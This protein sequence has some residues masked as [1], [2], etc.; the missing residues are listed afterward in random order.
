MR[1]CGGQPGRPI[2]ITAELHTRTAVRRSRAEGRPSAEEARG[3]TRTGFGGSVARA[4]QHDAKVMARQL[5]VRTIVSGM[6]LGSVLSLCN[7]YTGLKIGLTTNMSITAALLGFGFWQAMRAFGA[8]RFG[9]LENNLSQTAASA[10]A[11]VASAGLVAP[12]PALAI[13]TGFTPSWPVLSVWVLCVAGLGISVAVAL[14]RQMI[15]IEELPFPLGMAA[16]RTLEEM[17]S[18]GT[19]ALTRVG[20]LLAA[21]A[22]AASLKVTRELWLVG[23]RRVIDRVWVPGG[24]PASGAL[25]SSTETVT[26]ASLGFALDP[27][28]L[29]VGVGALIGLRAAASMVIG[30]VLAWGMLGPSVLAAGWVEPGAPGASWYATLVQWFLWPGVAVMVTASVA[31][32]AMRW[33][34]YGQAVGQAG[35]ALTAAGR[36]TGADVPRRWLRRVLAATLVAAV[37]GQV[38]IFSIPVW[39]ASLGVALTFLLAV[40]AARVSGET[41]VT[42]IGSMGKVTQLFF[43]V[44]APA[45]VTSNL[46]AANVT[47]GAASQCADLLHDFKTGQLLGAWPR[48]QALAQA[49]G[50]LA[51]ALAGSA[52]YLILVPDPQAMLLTDEWPAPAVV[53]WKA[54]AEL[55]RHGFSAMP[56]GGFLAMSMGAALGLGL[57]LLEY[58]LRAGGARGV[59]SAGGGGQEEGEPANG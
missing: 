29:M 9:L 35:D 22:F 39:V 41:G 42:P 30:A 45:N 33:P 54:V 28:V 46:M 40:V 37:A 23:G 1:S 48:H 18:R 2:R 31:S 4:E 11:S 16:A 5:T 3:A 12:I 58:R 10:G 26:F 27:S 47:G 14:R 32:V 21:A 56:P 7:I 51:G 59:P 15:E 24:V 13:L 53:K 17:Y 38:L 8:P 6:V 34:W 25:S 20:T 49:W 19:D 57:T 52:A 44:V 43:G 55:F 50:V 36:S